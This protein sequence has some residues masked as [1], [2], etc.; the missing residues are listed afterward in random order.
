MPAT[1][2]SSALPSSTCSS[3]CRCS[4][5]SARR[6]SA[7]ALVVLVIS[8]VVC[9]LDRTPRLWRGVRD[10]RVAQPEPFFDPRLPDRAAM[11]AV[12][13][14]DV[15]GRP[16]QERLPRPRGDRRRRD[17]LPLRRPP[18]VHEARDAVHPPRADPVPRRGRRRPRGSGDE[19]GLVVAEGE[20]L[21]GP[22]DRHARA[23]FSSRTST[24]RRPA[25]TPAR[26]PTSRP[27]WRSTRTASRS[28]ARRSGSTTRCPSRATRSTR[29]ASDR[30]RTRRP[31]RRRAG[32][33]GT[34]RCH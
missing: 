3:G 2:R 19:Q 9:T 8:I 30:R 15:R 14:E 7:S 18:P 26:R 17:A 1:T 12:P 21:D 32:R 16:A 13:A 6:G 5:S 4:R 33:C 27:I 10:I 24:S 25:S 22:A 20:S 28:R 34:G 23:S 11:D 31:R 29:T